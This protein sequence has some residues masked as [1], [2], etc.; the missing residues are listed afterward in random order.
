MATMN[1]QPSSVRA[2]IAIGSNTIRLVIARSTPDDRDIVVDREEPVHIGES[3]TATGA[4]SQEKTNAAIAVLKRYKG[5]ARGRHADQVLVVATEAIRQASNSAAFLE[6][7]QRKTNLA[8]HSISGTAEAALTFLGTT[9][10]VRKEPAHLAHIGVMDP[11]G[12]SLE[13]VTV[14]NKRITWR[15]SMAIGAGWLHDRFLSSDPPG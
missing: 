3:V 7:V 13:L 1:E 2:A 6:Q 8:V 11:E 12:E 10:E 5:Q 15:T 4:I 14:S 9:Y